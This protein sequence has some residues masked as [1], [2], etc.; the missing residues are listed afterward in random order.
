MEHGTAIAT[1]FIST[2]LTSGI[3]QTQCTSMVSQR[4]LNMHFGV[5]SLL[6][7]VSTVLPVDT[8]V[9][10]ASFCL[11]QTGSAHADCSSWTSAVAKATANRP[12]ITTTLHL[13]VHVS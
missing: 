7:I 5:S 8:L 11:G 4:L 1:L 6:K 10:A 2:P 3:L 9:D 12:V 13:N